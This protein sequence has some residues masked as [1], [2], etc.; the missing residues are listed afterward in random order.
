[1]DEQIG[2]DAGIE[3]VAHVQ[4]HVLVL[5]PRAETHDV[6][7]KKSCCELVENLKFHSL[8]VIKRIHSEIECT[9][10]HETDELDK[11]LEPAEFWVEAGCKSEGDSS[12]HE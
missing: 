2:D 4:L 3:T 10:R 9:Y 1:M 6:V 7:A 12:H 11:E 8:R 5:V